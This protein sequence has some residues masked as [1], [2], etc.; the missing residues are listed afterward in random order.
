VIEVDPQETDIAG[1]L[2]AIAAF[3]EVYPKDEE[4]AL[5]EF[6]P[7]PIQIVI[8]IFQAG[9]VAAPFTQSNAGNQGAEMSDQYN[10]TGAGAVGPNAQASHVTINQQ[11]PAT[12]GSFN[13]AQLAPELETLRQAMKKQADTVEQD[14][15]VYEVGQAHAAAIEGDEAQV[16]GHLQ[17]AGRW[18]MGI[19]GS[20]GSGLAVAAIKSALG[21]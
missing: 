13:L 17:R 5:R 3:G 11:S 7:R 20:I 8:N 15:S 18:A 21:L 1:L 14:A 16:M 4:A 9:A 19:A 10:V 12:N 2:R 6:K